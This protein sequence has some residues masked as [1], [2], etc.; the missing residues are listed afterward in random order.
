MRRTTVGQA[1][2][3]GAVRRTSRVC[4][5]ALLAVFSVHLALIWLLPVLPCQDLPQHLAYVRI[6]ADY[7]HNALFQTMF[8][9]PEHNQP[10]F[11]VY[12]LLAVVS[13]FMSPIDAARALMSVYV[14]GMFAAFGYL[15]RTVHGELRQS[16]APMA[17]PML[18]GTLL[19]WNPVVMMGFLSFAVAI[20]LMLFGFGLL[21]RWSDGRG[22]WKWLG[23]AAAVD[24]TLLSIHPVA[25]AV[26]VLLGL[27]HALVHASRDGRLR[28]WGGAV[29]LLATTGA[30][31]ALWS[32]F[33]A[34]GTTNGHWPTSG[35]VREAFR[36]ALGL[37]FI[38]QVLRISWGS[39]PVK[40][41][42]LLWTFLGPYRL[43]GLAL[44][45]ALSAAAVLAVLHDPERKRPK[46]GSAPGT[47]ML[48]TALAFLAI[49]WLAPWGF[50][51]PTEL[52]FLDLRLFTVAAALLLAAIPPG[53]FSSRRSQAALALLAVLAASHFAWR[54]TEFA[55]EARPVLRL[56]EK[57][58][59]P[60]RLASLVHGHRSLGF[61]KQFRL[62]HFLPMYYTV[63][64]GG[65]NSQFWARYTDH[66]PIGF[67]SDAYAMRPPDWR[68]SQFQRVQ[69]KESDFLLVQAP[70]SDAPRS[71]RDIYRKTLH[72]IRGVVR[73]MACER[74]W[75][76]YRVISPT[77]RIRATGPRRAD[78]RQPPLT[79][80]PW[81]R[82]TTDEGALFRDVPGH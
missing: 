81:E 51:V 82:D 77:H 16:S 43:P 20:P 3:N 17:C 45:G 11:T 1:V 22:S 80:P 66:L 63:I 29:G 8:E 54:A 72:D 41:S 34:T 6:F 36:Q 10:Y 55:G 47:S 7:D 33:G 18:L 4:L 56:L 59:P 48:R 25:A 9:L 65:A 52:T 69:L 60:G 39:P 19:V 38:T 57:A 67:K 23:G 35:T 62:T 76:L 13:R 5:G 40:L 2:S 28:R 71:S 46:P 27:V 21:L 58:R 49:A 74:D 26:L 78:R 15:C 70:A 68:V 61:A 12:R 73:E 75:C 32:W 50:F 37:E 30:G 24:L 79:P 42:Y 53:T 64:E 14:V 31:L 44:M